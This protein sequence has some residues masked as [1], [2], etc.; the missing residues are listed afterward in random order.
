MTL[1]ESRLSKHCE[2]NDQNESNDLRH[3]SNNNSAMKFF[4]NKCLSHK[5]VIILYI[6]I[7]Y[8]CVNMEVPVV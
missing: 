3:V 1:E 7:L 8:T 6:C 5:I 2:Y 4:V